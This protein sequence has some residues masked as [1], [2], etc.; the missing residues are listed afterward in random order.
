MKK[1]FSKS[2]TA[3][4]VA[5][6]L[7][8]L[9]PATFA[10]D[11]TRGSLKGHLE[12]NGA[13][14]ANA[15]I[16]VKHEGKG[17]TRTVT[18]S[19]TGD[20]NVK[21]LPPGK[22][23]ITISKP[24]YEAFEQKS[25]TVQA[26]NGNNVA[27]QMYPAGSAERIEVRGSVVEMID[28]ATNT[29]ALH[30]S[31]E[32]LNYL[33]V[34][35]NINSISLL[36]PGTMA[37][38]PAFGN[39]ASFGGASV[40]ENGYYLNGINITE[41]RNGAGPITLPWQMVAQTSTL[42]SGVGSEYGRHIGGVVNLTT[43]SGDN[44]FRFGA[45]VDYT[46]ESLY[47]KSPNVFGTDSDGNPILLVNSEETNRNRRDYSFWA[48][49]ALIEDK[50]FF[51]GLYNPVNRDVDFAAQ[52]FN[53]TYSANTFDS[54]FWFAKMDYYI[55]DDHAI[56]FQ[57]M[58]NETDRQ[59]FTYTYDY[60]GTENGGIGERNEFPT[61]IATGG[62]LWSV[63]Y[64]GN[65]GDDLSVTARYGV[66]KQHTIT[67]PGTPDRYSTFDGRVAGSPRIGNTAGGSTRANDDE[68]ISWRIDFDYII[69]DHTLR[70]GYDYD[71][72]EAT[73]TSIANGTDANRG[74]YTINVATANDALGI[75]EGTTYV[76][77][78]IFSQ[79]GTSDT[80]ASGFYVQDSWQA[81]DNVV[82]NMGVRVSEF[83]NTTTAGEI[84]AQ[85][86]NQIAPR[87]GAT[88]DVFG[89]GETKASVFYGRF[90]MSI[91]P[92]S[93]VRLAGQEFDYHEYYAFNGVNEA[94][95]EL[96]LGEKVRPDRVVSDGE[97]APGYSLASTNLKP[98]YS[99]EFSIAL[100]HQLNDEWSGGVRLI[101]RD[102]K[103]SIEDSSFDVNPLPPEYDDEGNVITYNLSYQYRFINPGSP[104]TLLY[105]T[106]GDGVPEELTFTAAEAGY[107]QSQR[108]YTSLE[109]T[110][111]GRPTDNFRLQG[112][113]TW[114]KSYGNTEGM[115]RSD[116]TGQQDAG[117][118]TSYDFPGLTDY[119]TGY[120]PN[121]RKHNFKLFGSYDVTEDLTLGF[122]IWAYS[123]IPIN[124]LG[125]HPTDADSCGPGGAEEAFCVSSLYR[126]L[127]F[128][129][130][131][132][133]TPRGSLG[134]T[135]WNYGLDLSANYRYDLGSMGSIDFRVAIQN[136]FNFDGVTQVDEDG[137]TNSGAINPN[138]NT[139]QNFQTPRNVLL[140]ATYQ[141]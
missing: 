96:D 52:G 130:N 90:F 5:A 63:S 36:A 136:V 22:Y 9:A 108:E 70:F 129:T 128:Y 27:I 119:G 89:D 103:S 23:T 59:L 99:D 78:R 45:R 107:P 124:S 53:S 1:L 118:T 69:G 40:A 91:A 24:G 97:V 15:T 66:I 21:G 113:Y 2:L 127:S 11:D 74:S 7:N 135:P 106:D 62:D 60:F 10:A 43:H 44:T 54:D 115:F 138:W 32:E 87:L 6:S 34:Q 117:L 67:A 35:R 116:S 98:M 140:S 72:L 86:K 114:S 94:T 25:F 93:N 14:I 122:N 141:F 20:F 104:V 123:G 49:G 101:Y 19:D 68:K 3:V 76:D 51:Y 58:N 8:L 64:N 30:L 112:S 18:S 65:I 38:D 132:Q 12:A 120:L 82:L 80:K 13:T 105:D 81:T 16:T 111:N 92:N 102:L 95:G 47:E 28:I 125:Y 50:L 139:P 57:G 61:N 77:R 39:I 71:H 134:R 75:A 37:G 17:L 131:G 83:T 88:W 33:P 121:D 42:T 4:A 56:E 31:T 46:P 29:Q 79:A 110:F 137:E 55:N 41:F 84:Y 109:L 133:P 73:T 85:Q 126:N 100:E 26:G 48:S